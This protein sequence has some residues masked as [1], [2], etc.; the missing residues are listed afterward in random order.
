MCVCGC[1]DYDRSG[2]LRF[3]P[4]MTEAFINIKK[5]LPSLT[6]EERAEVR[7]RIMALDHLTGTDTMHVHAV[8]SQDDDAASDC[9]R[10]FCAVLAEKGVEQVKAGMLRRTAGYRSFCEKVTSVCDWLRDHGITERADRM[11]MFKLGAKL[12]YAD[13]VRQAFAPVGARTMMAQV[14]R[15]PAALNASFPGYARSGL[16]RWIGKA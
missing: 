6:P 12:L 11:A 2:N 13:M 10:V 7:N 1:W 4:K 9:L 14:H 16:L 8:K 5:L 15:L 3:H